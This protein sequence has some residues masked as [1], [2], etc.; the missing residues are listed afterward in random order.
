M[1]SCNICGI[2]IIKCEQLREICYSCEADF[3]EVIEKMKGEY[4]DNKI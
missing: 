1:D 4:L 3:E 2:K